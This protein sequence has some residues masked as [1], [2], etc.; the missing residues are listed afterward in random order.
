MEWGKKDPVGQIFLKKGEVWKIGETTMFTKKGRQRRYS[1]A[2]LARNNLEYVRI[3]NGFK[4]I[5][6]RWIR[7]YERMLIRLYEKIEG[8]LPPG[9]KCRH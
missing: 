9:N 6:Q 7:K 5:N 8:R 2:W 3:K 4:A 1:A